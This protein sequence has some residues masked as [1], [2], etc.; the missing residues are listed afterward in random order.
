[1]LLFSRKILFGKKCGNL[2]PWVIMDNV[3]LCIKREIRSLSTVEHK[4]GLSSV[5]KPMF[6]TT[7]LAGVG[8]S[9]LG[10]GQFFAIIH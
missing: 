1:M 9:A 4:Q 8:R 3:D 10:N 6:L 5:T 7:R 2:Y